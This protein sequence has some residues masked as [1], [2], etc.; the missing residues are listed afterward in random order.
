MSLLTLL[1]RQPYLLLTL[2][3]LIWAGNAIAGKMA[4]GHVSPFL[5]T[6]IRW[7][8]ASAILLA[9]GWKLIR[10]EWPVIRRHLPYLFIMGTV[11]FTFFN[12]LMYLGLNYTTAINVAIEQASMPLVVFAVNFAIFGIRATP[13]QIIGFLL[14]LV[15]VALTVTG[16]NPLSILAQPVN[17]GDV[18]MLVA[19]FFYGLYTAALVRKPK[20]HWLTFIAVLGVSA[21]IISLP[22]AAWEILTGRVIWPDA[23]G[24]SVAFYTA[25]F[26]AI[27]AQVLWVRGM[28]II[29]SNRGGAFINLVPI[30]AAGL[31][32][33]LLGE[34]F[35]LYHAVAIALVLTGVWMS[36]RQKTVA[37]PGG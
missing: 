10:A 23:T 30:F 31:A 20:L 7:L 35:R 17:L 18:F 36:Q 27:V 25:V 14:T 24:V 9:F 32:I 26:P 2:T 37:T 1:S 22:F 28:E 15:G 8:V 13:L 16:G 12:N 11:G 4:V 19:V 21:F 3:A 33:L 29:G 5:L 6:S 34:E